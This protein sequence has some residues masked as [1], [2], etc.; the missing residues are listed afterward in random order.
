[1]ADSKRRLAIEMDLL[2]QLQALMSAGEIT[3]ADLIFIAA[4]LTGSIIATCGRWELDDFTVDVVR[5]QIRE[6]VEI[7]R[8]FLAKTDQAEH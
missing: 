1:M 4:T 3:G 5:E 2:K 7:V 8:G 6:R